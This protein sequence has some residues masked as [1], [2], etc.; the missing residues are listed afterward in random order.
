MMKLGNSILNELMTTYIS[1][2]FLLLVKVYLEGRI[3]EW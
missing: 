3:I 2:E 1:E